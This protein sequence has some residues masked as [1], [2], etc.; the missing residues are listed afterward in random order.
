MSKNVNIKI[1]AD[2]KDAQKEIKQTSNAL[3]NLAKKI[4]NSPITNLSKSIGIFGKAFGTITSSVKTV[5]KNFDDLN[6]SYLAQANAEKQLETACRNNPFLD[7]S[8]VKSLQD[9]ASA[10]QK[11]TTVGDETLLPLMGQ[12]ASAGRTQAEIQDI[13]TA[14]LDISASGAMSLES[15]VKNLNKTYGGLAGELGESIPQ[16]K[17]LTKEQL[18]QGDAV[19]LIAEQWNGTRNGKS[20]R[21]HT[22]IY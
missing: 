18:K 2:S 7:N 21:K 1:K 16:I 11:V 22:T 9:F 10:M 20:N 14:S 19:K 13:I 8:N 15:A 5:I 3:E 6:K 17:N 12:L 4:E